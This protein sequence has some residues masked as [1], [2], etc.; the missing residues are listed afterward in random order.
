MVEIFRGELTT[1]VFPSLDNLLKKASETNKKQAR[2]K[3]S[4]ET[5]KITLTVAHMPS[6]AAI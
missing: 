2:R 5:A 4:M 1:E 6:F 3:A